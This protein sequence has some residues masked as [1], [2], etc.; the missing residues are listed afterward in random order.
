MKFFV[1][2]KPK[3]NRVVAATDFEPVDG[4]KT[5]KAPRCHVC[6][7]YTG[8]LPLI[9]P[10]IVELETWTPNFGDIAWGPSDELLFSERLFKK[11]LAFN[12]CGLFDVGPVTVAKIKSHK[13]TSNLSPLYH[14]A[15]PRQS[16]AAIDDVHSGIER[17]EPWTCGECRVGGIIKR[18]RR[19]IL[20]A[21]SWS[22]EDIFFARGLPG[23][24]LIS[25]R[26]RDFFL[27]EKITNCQMIPAE[28][29][30]FDY[31]P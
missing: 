13:K 1:I 12:I 30:S 27:E 8:M 10:V 23:I 21:N 31:Y 20:E 2:Q 3:D 14:C 26:F 4:S 15:R 9:P 6:G 19:I 22:N 29:F 25:E 5:G 11:C 24:V 28:K 17:T 16:K 18:V 7:K